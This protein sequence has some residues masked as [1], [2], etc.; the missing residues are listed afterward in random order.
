MGRDIAAAVVEGGR[1]TR[2]GMRG[3]SLY[4]QGN[5][6]VKDAGGKR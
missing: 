6:V 3:N 1:R 5:S 2:L 4:R